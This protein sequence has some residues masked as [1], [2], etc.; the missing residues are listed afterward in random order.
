MRY[1][2]APVQGHTDAAYRHFHALHY[3]LEAAGSNPIEFTTPFIRLEK[4]ELRKKDL[5]DATAEL[6]VINRVVPQVIFKN[7]EELAVLVGRLKE[8]GFKR[9]DINMGCPFPLQ[10]SRGR[11]SATISKPECHEAVAKVVEDNRDVNFSLKMRLGYNEEEF[12]PLINELNHLTLDHITVHPRTAKDQY[13]PDSI[14]H[15]AFRRIYEESKNGVVYNG[16]ILTPA[17]ALTIS[18]EFPE[19]EGIMI[20]RGALGRPSIFNEI[21]SGEDWDIE[22][23]RKEMKSFHKE[24]FD[25]YKST[26]IGGDHQVL[27]KILPFWEYAEDE[28]GRKAWKAIKKSTNISK[29][30]SAIAL[31]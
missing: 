21:I 5:K 19:L 30:Q 15:E 12:I 27:S 22:R 10:T 18:S 8:E 7:Y 14:H 20:G 9:I 1:F 4:G 23:R 11:G 26:L 3:G 29:Y 28:I 24:L 25:Y 17:D 2:F 6:N 13:A 16:D 31:V